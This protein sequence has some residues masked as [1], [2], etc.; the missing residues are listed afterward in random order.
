MGKRLKISALDTKMTHL[1]RTIANSTA[2][3]PVETFT[4]ADAFYCALNYTMGREANE[5]Q[6]QVAVN[7]IVA[8]CRFRTD[9]AP[10]DRLR[11]PD[12]TVYNITEVADLNLYD[13]EINRRT[14]MRISLIKKDTA[15]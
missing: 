9:V 8:T 11:G 13:N 2:G 4:A 15:Q 10:T 14:W 7:T 3:Q 5:A 12:N 1:V 6:Q